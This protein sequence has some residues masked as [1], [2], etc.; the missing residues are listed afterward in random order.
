MSDSPQRATSPKRSTRSSSKGKPSPPLSSPSKKSRG[1]N[2][3]PDPESPPKRSTASIAQSMLSTPQRTQSRSSSHSRQSDALLTP[4][5][6]LTNTDPFELFGPGSDTKKRL[7]LQS[8]ADSAL[9][10]VSKEKL[11]KQPT[12]TS[13]PSLL[14]SPKR[15][16]T[17]KT[18]KARREA[19][20]GRTYSSQK[21]K[22]EDI[23]REHIPQLASLSPQPKPVDLLEQDRLK[24]SNRSPKHKPVK[25]EPR[26]SIR[27]P[28]ENIPLP[29]KF[30]NLIVLFEALDRTISHAR[31]VSQRTLSALRD[32]VQQRTRK[33]FDRFDLGRI[34]KVLPDLYIVETVF[35]NKK[36]QLVVC[37]APEKGSSNRVTKTI[38]LQSRAD[39][40]KNVLISLVKDHIAGVVN[41]A[42]AS[43]NSQTRVKPEDIERPPPSYNVDD[44]PD[45]VPV[46][47]DIDVASAPVEPGLGGVAALEAA[48]KS[49]LTHAESQLKTSVAPTLIAKPP[50]RSTSNPD[51]RGVSQSLIERIR[52]KE[53]KKQQ[54]GNA[55]AAD[56]EEKNRLSHIL[57][58]VLYF[59]WGKK[60]ISN[61]SSASMSL[62][63]LCQELRLK[64]KNFGPKLPQ[65]LIRMLNKEVAD[66]CK[67]KGVASWCW[68][69]RIDDEGVEVEYFRVSPEFNLSEMKA[70][71]TSRLAKL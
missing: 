48:S 52:A 67:K 32:E 66:V 43:G 16:T 22:N 27:Q 19:L 21:V 61:K 11:S 42:L 36:T 12:L 17:F 29:Q 9:A 47:F 65:I 13:P 63:P 14:L 53:Q 1:E 7:N 35:I 38:N 51:L 68:I 69:N 58:T 49:K 28:S 57:K 40:L 26:A 70:H 50:A 6:K 64:F 44:V 5:K 15:E 25:T 34:M 10:S 30:K 2:F 41:A 4:G 31:K 8:R 3:T 54:F 59:V 23:K 60:P 18:P 39:T 20:Q 56:T 46:D 71:I 55:A 62:I 37:N 45:I 33:N 24:L